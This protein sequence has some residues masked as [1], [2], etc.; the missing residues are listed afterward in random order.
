MPKVLVGVPSMDTVVLPFHNSFNN[1]LKCDAE[2]GIQ[3][4]IGM[5]VVSARNKIVSK[6]LEG[7]DYIFF[8]DSDMAFPPE[9]LGNLLYHDVDIVGGFYRRK[10]GGYLPNAFKLGFYEDGQLMT[11]VVTDF[12]EVE[13]I[14]TGCLLVKTDVFRSMDSPWFEYTCSDDKGH[15]HTE[16]IVF[17]RKAKEKGYKIY[18]DG[19]INCGHVGMFIVWPVITDGKP[20]VLIDPV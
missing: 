8:M 19:N 20:N 11:E 12:K 3:R 7:Y 5:N 6:G 17:C 14:G 10:K 1:A 13:A 4:V 15:M 2:I 18:C 9:T 16:D